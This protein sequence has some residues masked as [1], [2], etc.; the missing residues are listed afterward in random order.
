[1]RHPQSSRRKSYR[2]TP[3]N[4]RT[5]LPIPSIFFLFLLILITAPTP[6]SSATPVPAQSP[7]FDADS[8]S[9]SIL[10][11][12]GFGTPNDTG[13]GEDDMAGGQG[14][15]DVTP[16]TVTP[17]PGNQWTNLSAGFLQVIC[18]N[19][20]RAISIGF[21]LGSVG[22]WVIHIFVQRYFLKRG[23]WVAMLPFGRRGS[24]RTDRRNR[25]GNR[26]RYSDGRNSRTRS[27]GEGRQAQMRTYE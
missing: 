12:T 27:A 6:L 24:R 21:L 20:A 9:G 13:G 25:N 7:T 26:N 15:D 16:I 22:T 5:A 8:V 18:E 3:R 19:D 11:Y 10:S 4:A 23:W 17:P 2:R 14:S 1:M